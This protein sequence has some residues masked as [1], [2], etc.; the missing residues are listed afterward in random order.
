MQVLAI[1]EKWSEK[2]G[3][4]NEDIHS[5]KYLKTK[6]YIVAMTETDE[7]RKEFGDTNKK[8]DITNIIELYKEMKE[9]NNFNIMIGKRYFYN[10]R[11]FC[12]RN[13]SFDNFIR[14][15]KKYVSNKI[16]N[17]KLQDKDWIIF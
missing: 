15:T 5:I 10:K 12:K 2:Y 7:E 4:D 6:N 14:K 16:K 17:K 9:G 11:M 1:S 13:R 8:C 3:Y